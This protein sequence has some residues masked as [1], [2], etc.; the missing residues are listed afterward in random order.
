MDLIQYL[1]P[2]PQ[3]VGVVGV[4][5]QEIVDLVELV[6]P[7]VVADTTQEAIMRVILAVLLQIVIKDLLEDQ[8]TSMDHTMVVVVAVVLAVLVAML[9][10][11]L[12]TIRISV[13]MVV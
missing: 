4:V 2:S 3:Q 13:V 11:H 1:D 5:H 6:D 8:D 12:A 7:V 9:L 10:T